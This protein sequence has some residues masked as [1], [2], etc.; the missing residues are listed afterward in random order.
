MHILTP[1]ES[2][3]NTELGFTHY[4]DNH[5]GEKKSLVAIGHPS[6]GDNVKHLTGNLYY[7]YSDGYEKFGN[8]YVGEFID[9]NI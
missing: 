7:V 9:T 4:V 5:T 3:D 8:T 2:I 1:E 6:K